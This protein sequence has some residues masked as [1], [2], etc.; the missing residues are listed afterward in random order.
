M[1]ATPGVNLVTILGEGSFHQVHGGSTT[2]VPDDRERRRRVASHGQ[3][4]RSLRARSFAVADKRPYYIGRLGPT[5]MRTK[6]RWRRG[7]QVLPAGTGEPPAAPVLMR[8]ELRE[9]FT[10]AYWHSLEWRETTWCG[11][12]VP[13]ST[14][15][16]VAYR[17]LV[18]GLRP[19]WVV[20][21]G[22]EDPRVPAFW[23]GICATSGAG[24]VL[25]VDGGTLD[26]GDVRVRSIPGDPEAAEVAAVVEG[27][28]GDEDALVVLAR[29]PR[30]QV[31]ARFERYAPLV[32]VG[33]YLVVEDTIVNG[34]P[35]WPGFGPGP[36][37]AVRDVLAHGHGFQADRSFERYGPSFNPMGYL[38][39]TEA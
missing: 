12:V 19:R 10:A 17:E 29:A 36:M 7:R 6:P 37:E 24:Q 22:A 25:S 4:Y 8:A 28:C 34:H 26:H 33:G 18:A 3:D 27:L 5:A 20:V 15:D 32:P 2:N 38:R 13:R 31:L 16:L 11:D 9:E 35:V 30:A 21:V 1:V 23:A 14:A 39:R